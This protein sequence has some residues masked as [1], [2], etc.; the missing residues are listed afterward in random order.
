[1]YAD[2]EIYI[3]V[4]EDVCK[5]TI[6][7]RV[8]LIMT[9]NNKWV[10]YSKSWQLYNWL[11]RDDDS[12]WSIID[13]LCSVLSSLVTSI[14]IESTSVC[15]MMYI[16]SVENM[17]CTHN[18]VFNYHSKLIA[19]VSPLWISALSDVHFMIFVRKF[20]IRKP[21][22][23]ICSY[24]FP[25]IEAYIQIKHV[26]YVDSQRLFMKLF[27]ICAFFRSRGM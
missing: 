26:A 6:L 16:I 23:S 10:Y 9:M 4:D 20:Q 8:M 15:E 22:G 14:G 11:K 19:S 24:F 1:M 25:T 3:Y 7:Y 13:M 12:C 18:Y 17:L 21:S 27:T 5:R 2:D